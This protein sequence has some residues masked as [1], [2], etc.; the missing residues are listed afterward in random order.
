MEDKIMDTNRKIDEQEAQI[1][2]LKAESIDLAK[3]EKQG[4]AHI[5]QLKA[6]VDKQI[7]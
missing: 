7:L 5:E 4:I 3:R 1:A 2:E 6:V